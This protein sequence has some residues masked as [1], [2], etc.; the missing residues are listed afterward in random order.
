LSLED[1]FGEILLDHAKHPRHYG[2]IEDAE[3]SVEGANPLC[4]D[5]I[6][7][8]AKTRD[9]VIE[10]IGFTGRACSICTASTSIFCE[11]ARGGRFTDL[12][13]MKERFYKM[14]HGDTVTGEEEH[15]LGDAL[16]LKGVAKLPARVKCA[17]L[18]YETWSVMKR[19]LLGESAAPVRASSE[20]ISRV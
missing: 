16:A 1:L 7:L 8:F 5:E 17:T 2:R 3:I 12:D 11:S 15:Q 18:V 4:G 14:L 10:A 9:G 20:K 13:G 6:E 19:R